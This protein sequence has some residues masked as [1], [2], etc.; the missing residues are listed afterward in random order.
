MEEVKQWVWGTREGC[1]LLQGNPS[2]QAALVSEEL[3]Y[4]AGWQGRERHKLLIFF[5]ISSIYRH[6][7]HCRYSG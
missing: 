7:H 3:S 4:H 2:S 5:I 6:H 1:Q